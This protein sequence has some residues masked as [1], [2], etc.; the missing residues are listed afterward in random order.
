[1]KRCPPSLIELAL[2][3]VLDEQR[4]GLRH[5]IRNRL[6]GARNAAFY[7]E[8]KVQTTGLPE[9]DPR[10]PRFFQIITESIT[11]TCDALEAQPPPF[12]PDA[13]CDPVAALGE[14]I[15]ALPA[16][17]CL[18]EGS[19]PAAAISA[20]ELQLAA[21]FLLDAALDA[22][23]PAPR[24]VIGESAPVRAGPTGPRAGRVRVTLTFAGPFDPEDSAGRVAR[25]ILA[26]WGAELDAWE[27]QGRSRIDLDLPRPRRPEDAPEGPFA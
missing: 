21:F 17:G 5:F 7:L 16:P 18:L 12:D 1:M 10:V 4:A 9:S 22:G 19:A 2:A 20:E 14:L 3:H 8:R 24:L 27:D 26:R 25:R 11:D 13:T 15:A 6:G 23:G